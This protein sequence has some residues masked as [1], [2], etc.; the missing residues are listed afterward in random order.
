MPFF[1]VTNVVPLKP[2]GC[3]IQGNNEETC[4]FLRNLHFKNGIDTITFEAEYVTIFKQ[5]T[6]LIL[7]ELDRKKMLKVQD[8]NYGI[9]FKVAN[10]PNHFIAS[11]HFKDTSSFNLLEK[12]PDGQKI[13][14][15]CIVFEG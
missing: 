14:L 10:C 13:N 15:T 5:N 1:I 3:K 8:L 7:K 6:S 2:I 11:Y 9:G 4:N 12:Q